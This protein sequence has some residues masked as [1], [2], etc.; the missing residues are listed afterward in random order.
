[1]V[2]PAQASPQIITRNGKPSAVIVSAEEW[3]RKTVRKGTGDLGTAIT[4][5]LISQGANVL[6][7][8]H[9]D[10]APLQMGWKRREAVRR[11]ARWVSR[12]S[13]S[14]ETPSPDDASPKDQ[15]LRISAKRSPMITQ[16]AW[17]LPEAIVGMIEPSAMRRFLTP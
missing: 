9:N 7:V 11:E 5:R 12:S 4:R 16:G 13:R 17:V 6:A 2:D 3:A 10:A 14:G 1:M 8:A 15:A